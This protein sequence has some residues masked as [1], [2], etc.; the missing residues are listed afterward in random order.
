MATISP[1]L[2]AGRILDRFNVTELIEGDVVEGFGIV[3][4]AEMQSDFRMRVEFKPTAPEWLPEVRY[5]ARR[6]YLNVWV[7]A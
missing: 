3:G 5:F 6:E 1:T 2:T 4:K 7:K